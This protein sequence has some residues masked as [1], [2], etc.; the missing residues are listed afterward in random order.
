MEF[1][2]IAVEDVDKYWITYQVRG[3]WAGQE[4]DYC[5]PTV[6]MVMVTV[7]SA[8]HYTGGGCITWQMAK[9]GIAICTPRILYG[10]IMRCIYAATQHTVPNILTTPTTPIQTKQ[11]LY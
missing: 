8:R 4:K 3:K 6:L 2:D 10:T 11:D 5:M 1:K 9:P 7:H